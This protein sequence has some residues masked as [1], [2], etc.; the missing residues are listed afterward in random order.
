MTKNCA[1]GNLL[2]GMFVEGVWALASVV[3]EKKEV[4]RS[5]L[6]WERRIVAWL[7]SQE[8]RAVTLLREVS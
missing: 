4:P 7:C 5:L 8:N 6:K 1:V 2:K 3:S